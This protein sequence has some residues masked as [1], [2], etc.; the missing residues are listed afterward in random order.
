MARIIIVKANGIIL[1]GLKRLIIAVITADP[2][3]LLKLNS[4]EALA[5]LSLIEDIAK[6]D[7]FAKTK[8]LAKKIRPKTKK[9]WIRVKESLSAKLNNINPLHK[10]KNT[11]SCKTFSKP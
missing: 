1:V 6:A 3:I 11:P 9:N 7:A 10:T 8:P 2:A 4:A 5:K